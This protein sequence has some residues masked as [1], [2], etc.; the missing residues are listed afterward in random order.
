MEDSA[1]FV[2]SDTRG[3]GWPNE[4]GVKAEKQQH[5]NKEL[6]SGDEGNSSYGNGYASD[7][8]LELRECTM[9]VWKQPQHQRNRR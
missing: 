6:L 7:I 2:L 8:T 1:T 5:G 4:K 9:K 3:E